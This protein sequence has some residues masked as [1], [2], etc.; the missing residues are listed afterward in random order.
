MKLKINYVFGLLTNLG[1]D[2]LNLIFLLILLRG[3][4][5]SKVIFMTRGG[6]V[7][8]QKVIFDDEGGGGVRQ[9]VIFD[10]EGG[11]GV[12]TPSKKDDIIYE[13]PLIYR[14]VFTELMP[15]SHR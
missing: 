14:V 10:D 9:K 2:W 5:R 11:R 13:Q 7:V 3:G 6:G 1:W 15:F 12:Q 8:R 4:S